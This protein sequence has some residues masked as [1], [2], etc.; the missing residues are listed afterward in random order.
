MKYL[1]SAT[2][3]GEWIVQPAQDPLRMLYD[4]GQLP[5]AMEELT[6]CDHYSGSSNMH[7][8][9]RTICDLLFLFCVLVYAFLY[10]RT[11]TWE[12]TEHIEF[13]S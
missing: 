10:L 7:L 6:H 13:Q 5:V 12:F 11:Q 1:N 3:T 8:L 9:H 4:S 2:M